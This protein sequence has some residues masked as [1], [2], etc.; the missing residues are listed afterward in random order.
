[1]PRLRAVFEDLGFENIATVIASGNVVFDTEP[2]P[3]LVVRIETALEEALGFPVPTFLFTAGEFNELLDAQ[4]F[5]EG[6]GPIEVSVVASAPDAVTARAVEAA[7]TGPDRV[8]IR[9]RAVYWQRT[10]T[11]RDSTHSEAAVMR[12]LGTATTRRGLATMRR[13]RDRHL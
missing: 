7:A 4:P 12:G 13:I 2:R 11:R 10:G 5:D 1:M 9:G 8:A 6:E 3:D